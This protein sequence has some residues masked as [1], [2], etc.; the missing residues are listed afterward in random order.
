VAVARLTSFVFSVGKAV[1]VQRL[2]RG[3]VLRV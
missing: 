2:Y 3:G 1:K